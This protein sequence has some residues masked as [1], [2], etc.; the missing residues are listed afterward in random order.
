VHPFLRGA[1]H[2]NLAG[3]RGSC[4]G[5]QQGLALQLEFRE[6]WRPPTS[7]FRRFESRERERIWVQVLREATIRG[8]V[9]AILMLTST[10]ALWVAWL[11]LGIYDGL[12]LRRA[13]AQDLATLAE[14][15]GQNGASA[16]A[17]SDRNA[18]SQAL[19]ALRASP[20]VMAAGAYSPEGNLLA[21]YFRVNVSIPLPPKALRGEEGAS[22]FHRISLFHPIT[23]NGTAVGAIYVESDLKGWKGW[24]WG[25]ALMTSLGILALGGV[26]FLSVRLRHLI[27]D[28]IAGLVQPSQAAMGGGNPL[29]PGPWRYQDEL[30]LSGEGIKEMHAQI[31]ERDDQ[32]RKLR[33]DLDSQ[34][35][36][37]TEELQAQNTQLTFEKKEAEQAC[38]AQS[39][40]LANMS[41][42]IRTPMNAIM[43][44]TELALDSD[45]DP[46]RREYLGL[47][48]S[49]AESLLTVINDIL[50]VSKIEAGKLDIDQIEF[51]LRDCL[52]EAL[53]TL[54]LRAHEKDLELAL[55]VH[56]DVADN[57]V[58]DP[59]RVRQIVFNLVGNS[60]KFTE[61]GEVSVRV[62]VESTS[63]DQTTLHIAVADTGIGVPPE[64]RRVIF[65]AFAQADHSISRRYGG[66]GL[67]L[68]ISSRLVAMMGGRMWVES[69]VGKGSTFHFN[70]NLLRAKPVAA[71]GAM[72]EPSVLQGIATLVVDDNSTNLQILDELL[73][74]WG[75]K[76]TLAENGKRGI[77]ILEHTSATGAAF[78]LILLDS[79][80]PDMDGFTFARHVKSDPRFKG[81]IIMML[82]SGGERGD[83]SRC[84]DLRISAYLV[85]PIQQTELLEAILTVLGHKTEASGQRPGLVTRHSLREDRRHLRILLAEDNPVNQMVASRLLEKMGHTV[86]VVG[87]G[88]EAVMML[89]KQEFGLVLMDVQMPE[90]D[91][92]ETT[93]VIRE[94][95]AATGK[96]IPIIA[97]TAHAMKGD[98]ERCL[99]AGMDGYIAKPIRP[100]ELLAGI[101]GFTRRPGP[102]PRKPLAL[103]EEDCIDWQAAWAN[104]EGDRNLLSELAV[105][106]LDDLP[107]QM[108]AIHQAADKMQGDDLERFAH[109]LKGSVGNFAAKPAFEAAFRLEEIAR[110]GDLQHAP[111]AVSALESE[112]Q[113]LKDA[114]EKWVNKPLGIEEAGLPLAPPPPS[115][116]LNSALNSGSG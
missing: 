104:L 103:P 1:L 21:T 61:R 23:R 96:H 77:E 66:T 32:L 14:I 75:M 59:S 101:E 81:A 110:Q 43:G 57:F 97:M 46:T 74:H 105:V 34:I 2:G 29:P 49:S 83:A 82:T 48:K 102:A 5:S 28:P 56:P 15:V 100:A 114:L 41:H 60:I 12:N 51:N 64:K 76:P 9:L 107:Q 106:F 91:G 4:Q 87:N 40:F 52:G 30:N 79:Q 19:S 55:R 78:P 10:V 70:L 98:R 44:M 67:G 53:K 7:W 37:R 94:K 39:E 16:L 11:A 22:R 17:S 6:P 38:R 31:K 65:D 33:E 89:E 115:S 92:F 8:K 116:T 73:S 71:G 95:E 3:R 50:D 111:Q 113:R 18:A 93:R 35:A 24:L 54:A 109:R 45:A 90:M 112:I 72:P 26:A 62:S 99:A 20:D 88:R 84:R 58:G 80:M 68:T 69:E 25:H 42:E 85:K 13:R 27:S 63:P 86:M 108:E 36:A 47:V